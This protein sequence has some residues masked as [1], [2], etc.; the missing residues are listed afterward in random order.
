MG[1]RKRTGSRPSARE[2]G[3]I[4]RRLR[5]IEDQR[6]EL[7]RDIGGLA[8]EMHKRQRLEPRLLTERAAEAAAL[9]REAARLREALEGRLDTGQPASPAERSTLGAPAESRPR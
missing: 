8:L 3:R 4:R 6:E 2:R 7:L 5:E 1:L 9:D